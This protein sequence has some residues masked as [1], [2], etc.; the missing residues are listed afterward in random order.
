MSL[1]ALGSGDNFPSVHR[2][3]MNLSWLANAAQI[4]RGS[5]LSYCSADI[6][7]HYFVMAR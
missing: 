4:V 6:S 3:I 7:Q 2:N 5:A 1:E